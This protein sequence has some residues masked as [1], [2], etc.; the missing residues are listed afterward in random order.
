MEKKEKIRYMKVATR[1]TVQGGSQL[2]T[3]SVAQHT[4]RSKEMQGPTQA[5][6]DRQ[7]NK[8][9]S[10]VV[11]LVASVVCLELAAASRLGV[12]LEEFLAIAVLW[13]ACRL[14][15]CIVIKIFRKV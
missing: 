2:Q 13:A 5:V 1:N 12:R 10:M 3:S 9:G 8:S 15:S 7:L 11:V 14:L 4:G 6:R